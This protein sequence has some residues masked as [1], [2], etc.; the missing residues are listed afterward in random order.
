MTR[1][2]DEYAAGT[3]RSLADTALGRDLWQ[4]LTEELTVARLE[5][6]TDLAK[7]AVFGIEEQLL[8]RFGNVVADDRVKQMIGHMVR[9]IMESKGY[10]I[11]RRDV[12]IASALFSKGTRYG[13]P[14]WQR[15]QVFRNGSNA[16]ELCFA[17]RRDTS[18]LPPPENGGKWRFWASFASILR[19]QIAYGV[20]VHAV[21]QE[22]AAKGYALRTL[23]R[24]LHPA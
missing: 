20:D 7:P 12:T 17:D 14:D 10:R 23:E 15:L 11:D 4:F 3:F 6:A 24:I 2:N 18:K 9:Q 22:V 8:Q 13:R 16:R 21:R 19:G 5:T 1:S